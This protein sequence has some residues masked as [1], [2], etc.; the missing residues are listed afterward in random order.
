M[1]AMLAIKIAHGI[2]V[3]CVLLQVAALLL[4][5]LFVAIAHPIALVLR[6]LAIP[7]APFWRNVANKR[8]G[9]NPIWVTALIVV[10]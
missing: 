1:A 2:V 9:P 5:A 7:Q 10:T 4:S 8:R 3:A 6:A